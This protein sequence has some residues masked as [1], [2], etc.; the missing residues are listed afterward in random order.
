[1]VL[2]DRNFPCGSLAP[3]GSSAQ[4]RGVIAPSSG[5]FVAFGPA[6]SVLTQPGQQALIRTSSRPL[7]RI[8]RACIHVMTET[9]T[10]D[11]PYAVSGHPC[12]TWSPAL[13]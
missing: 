4:Y 11:T 3:S 7:M 2:S 5:D 8:C 1:M 6:M 9:P 13:A 10:F 12:V